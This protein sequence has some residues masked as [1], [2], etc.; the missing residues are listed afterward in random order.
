VAQ[1]IGTLCPPDTPGFAAALA[2]WP[3]SRS[4]PADGALKPEQFDIMK[5]DWHRQR[6]YVGF[7]ATA[8]APLRRRSGVMAVAGPHE[9]YGGK[10]V[11]MRRRC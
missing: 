6:P 4:L 5:V 11:M 1:T 10:V 7:A 3:A 8:S 9:G 2:R